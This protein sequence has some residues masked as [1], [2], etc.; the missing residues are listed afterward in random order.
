MSWLSCWA[1]ISYQL[2]F[3]LHNY[4]MGILN[5]CR[6]IHHKLYTSEN[7]TACMHHSQQML[8]GGT[9]SSCYCWFWHYCST[10]QLL[11]SIMWYLMITTL[12]I[13]TLIPCNT[14]STISTNT[15]LLTLN[16]TSYQDNIIL[17]LT[18]SY[19]MLVIYH[20]LETEPTR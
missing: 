8:W 15:S 10:Q 2:Q 12:P 20:L 6:D 4:I 11:L 7:L 14:T 13:T 16:Y 9:S 19:N 3:A 17:I 18:W 5:V 1:V